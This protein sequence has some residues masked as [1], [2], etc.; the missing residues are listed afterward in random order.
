MEDCSGCLRHFSS[1]IVLGGFMRL[2]KQ[3]AVMLVLCLLLSPTLR[4]HEVMAFLIG[5]LIPRWHRGAVLRR[6]LS[7]RKA[8]SPP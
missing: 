3:A 1:A 5:S 8:S 7:V 2:S 4:K 6:G